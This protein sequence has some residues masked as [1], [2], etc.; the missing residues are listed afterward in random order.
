MRLLHK[1]CPEVDSQL[2]SLTEESHTPRE[3]QQSEDEPPSPFSTP[4]GTPKNNMNPKLSD[5][6]PRNKISQNTN[7]SF[8]F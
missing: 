6:S 7:Q 8:D 3:E 5:K 4:P 2:R 1:K